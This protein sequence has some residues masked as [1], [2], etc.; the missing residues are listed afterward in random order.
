MRWL[1]I[2]V[3]ALGALCDSAFGVEPSKAVTSLSVYPTVLKLKGMDD[4]PQLLISGK[5]SDGREIDLT[6]TASYNVSDPKVIRVEPSGRVFPITN[7]TAEITATVNGMTVKV[8]VTSEKMDTP[9]PINFANH[10]VPVFTKLGCSSGGCH[11]KIAGQNGFR[12]SLLGFD[13]RFDYDNLMKEARGRRVFPAAPEKSLLLTKATG[14][15]AHGGGKKIEV[16]S[17]EYK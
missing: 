10:V 17:E 3:L 16:G 6:P 4:A 12:L 15:A 9:L 2:P 1:I 14:T 5:R 11:G 8:S 13:P 7:G